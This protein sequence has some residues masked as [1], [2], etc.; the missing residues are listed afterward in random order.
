MINQIAVENIFYLGLLMV[1]GTPLE[2][3]LRVTGNKTDCFCHSLP[4]NIYITTC[5][6]IQ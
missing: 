2:E 1:Q 3:L 5:L 6:I 4:K